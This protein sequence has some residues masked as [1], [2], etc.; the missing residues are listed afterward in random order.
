M[1]VI[2]TATA[3]RGLLHI[4]DYLS[5]FNPTAAIRVTQSLSLREVGDNLAHFP[6]RGR[7]VPGTLMREQVTAYPYIIRYRIDGDK[8][9]ILRVRHGARRPTKP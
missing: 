5:D 6:Y 4:Y 3:L 7:L 8:V 9:Y 2:W 1:R